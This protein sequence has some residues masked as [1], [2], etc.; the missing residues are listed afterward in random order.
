[1]ADPALAHELTNSAE[2]LKQ[3][4]VWRVRD[5]EQTITNDVIA[6]EV[7]VALEYNGISHAVMLAT[8]LDLP[9]F[10]L[11]FS[12]TEGILDGRCELYGVEEQPGESGIT[13]RLASNA[14]L[15]AAA[16]CCTSCPNEASNPGKSCALRSIVLR[17][18]VFQSRKAAPNSSSSPIA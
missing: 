14:D 16:P 12:L 4:S 11:G 1:M 8:P 15:S 18:P 10:A 2:S 6:V 3:V 5:G 17:L 7:P 9:D 13:L